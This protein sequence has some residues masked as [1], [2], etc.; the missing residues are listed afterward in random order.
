MDQDK[1]PLRVAPLRLGED[2]YRQVV[3]RAEREDVKPSHMLRR[4]V[5]F[6]LARMPDYWVPTARGGKR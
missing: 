1:Q 4:M 3:E 6:S 5:Q 2:E